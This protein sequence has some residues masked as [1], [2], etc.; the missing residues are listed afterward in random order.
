MS[1]KRY[2]EI[3]S[4]YRNRNEYP[5]P[6]NF[7]A[8]LSQTG[9]RTARDAYDPVSIAAPQKIWIPNNLVLTGGEILTPSSIATQSEFIAKFPS[10]NAN[11]TH[12]YYKGYPI[13]VFSP[14]GENVKIVEWKY[15]STDGTNDYF[16]INVSPPFSEVPYGDVTFK[17]AETVNNLTSGAIFIPDGFN[18]DEVYTGC[19]LYNQNKNQFRPIISYDSTTRLISLDL[20]DA[21]IDLDWLLDETL[22]I[23]KALPQYTGTLVDGTSKTTFTVPIGTRINVGDMIRFTGPQDSSNENQVCRV[24]QYTGDNPVQP[25]PP[26]PP[27]PPPPHILP[28]IVTINCVLPDV[29]HINDTFE[30]LQFTRDNVVPINYTGS[31]VSQQ[32]MVCYEIELINLVLPTQTLTTGSLALYPYVYVELQNVSAASSGTNGVIYSNNPHARRRLFR[33]IIN[34]NPNPLVSPY[35]KLDGD[36]MVQT[37]K[38]KPNDNL[39]FGVYLP[40]G[41][42]FTTVLTDSVSPNAPNPLLQISAMFSIRRL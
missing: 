5:N 28:N 7:T 18:V 14:N 4:T 37:V 12:N 8:L 10:E 32:E 40:D 26:P 25:T 31:T 2:L 39:K 19:I 36:G 16:T 13:N 24:V 35:I 1:N 3:D 22:I 27:C 29:P 21:P 42:P 41:S 9:T 20:T 6:S 15:L 38:F 11:V 34:D 23:R 17:T 33:S 30:I